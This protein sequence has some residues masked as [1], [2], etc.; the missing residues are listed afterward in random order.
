MSKL[1]VQIGAEGSEKEYV[2]EYTRENICKAEQV[3]GV[4][5][6]KVTGE[7]EN[8]HSLD[9]FLNC[10]VYA[11]LLKN[12]PK[13]TKDNVRDI[14]NEL[15]GENGYEEESLVK[16]LSE[17]LSDTLNPSGGGRKKFPKV[18]K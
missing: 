15:V 7:F 6:L 2:F 11:G 18:K 16:G 4:S 14:Y 3:F 8:L 1:N 10:I 17:L 12:H 5:L 9:N 13:I